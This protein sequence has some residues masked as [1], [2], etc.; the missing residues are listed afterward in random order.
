MAWAPLTTRLT[1]WLETL[2]QSA[3]LELEELNRL[4]LQKAVLD[5]R[6]GTS[7]A[8]S[9]MA[10]FAALA[11]DYPVLTTELVAQALRIT[12][13]GAGQLLRR[14][15]GVVTEITGRSRYRVWRL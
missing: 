13:Q 1:F 12:P 6:V 10:E 8:G 9:K 15:A 14:M 11:L 7:R 5:R 4:K 2:E 3:R